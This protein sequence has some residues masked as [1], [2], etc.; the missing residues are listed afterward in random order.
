[1]AHYKDKIAVFYNNPITW[2]VFLSLIVLVFALTLS[3]RVGDN[4]IPGYQDFLSSKPNEMGDTLAGLAGTLAFIW[5]VVTVWLQSNEL[6]EQREQLKL[7]TIEFRETNDALAAQ[8][9]DQA[10]FGLLTA[11]S[12]IVSGIDLMSYET[13]KKG[14]DC[15]N[16][17]ISSLR[18]TYSLW[19]KPNKE[20]GREDIAFIYDEFWSE[21]Q[22]K[23][24]HYFRFLYNS[25]R[26]ISENPDLA[27]PH[28]ARLLRSQLSDQ[29]LLLI[30]YNCLSRQGKK[31]LKYAE[32]F[33]LFD[34]LPHKLLFHPFDA[35]LGV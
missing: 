14:R 34:N 8:R 35:H 20:F 9:F 15:F 25:F 30:Y 2:G 32:Q 28:H 26:F 16:V 10:F 4:G 13:S 7:Q 17:F 27:K 33:A 21:Y 6:S 22:D 5:I 12:E 29:E 23:L 18:Y 24:G 19:R 1:M 11:Y 31:F 3:I